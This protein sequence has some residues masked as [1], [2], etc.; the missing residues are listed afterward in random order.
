MKFQKAINI[1]AG[2]IIDQL[3]SGAMRLQPGQWIKCGADAKPSRYCGATPRT[4]IAAH[5]Q[6]KAG[7]QISRFKSHREYALSIG[8]K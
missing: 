4:I 7:V 2:D 5:P 1:W 8:A 3:H 6:G